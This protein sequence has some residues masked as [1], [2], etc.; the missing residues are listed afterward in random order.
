MCVCGYLFV[1]C[2]Y[3]YVH[4]AMYKRLYVWVCIYAYA[5]VHDSMCMDM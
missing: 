4:V 3:V 1:L 2:M 5:N